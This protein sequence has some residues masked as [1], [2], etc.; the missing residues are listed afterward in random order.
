LIADLPADTGKIIEKPWGSYEVLT[1]GDGYQVKRITVL[2]A[3]ALS[4][5]LHRQRAEVWIV[6]QGQ[7]S[8]IVQKTES[9]VTVGDV[10]QV[11]AE[12]QH[13][14]RNTGSEPLLLI[15]VQLGAYLEEDDI[16]RLEDLYGR[17]SDS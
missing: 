4:L 13:R 1:V 14:V 8:V 17:S 12:S 6:V 9:N 16:V 3:Q 10:V 2:P 15:E 5:Q 11:P 7:G